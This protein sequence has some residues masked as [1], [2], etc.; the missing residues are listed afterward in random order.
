VTKDT[1]APVFLLGVNIGPAQ[2]TVTFSEDVK[3]DGSAGAAD[4]VANYLLFEDGANNV[5]NTV[6]CLGGVVADD[7]NIVINSVTYNVATFTVT[8]NINGSVPL[9]AGTYRLLVCG[10][11]SIED[12]A[13][14]KLN[15]GLADSAF[16]FTVVPA[17]AAALP[18][19]GFAPGRVTVL[20][21]QTVSYA[22]MGDLWLEIPKLGVQ[23]NIVGVPKTDGTW[24]VSWLGKYA[25]WLDGSA[26]PTWAGNSVLTGH[27]WN[28]DNSAG[29]FLAIN[30]L[31]WGDKVIIHA[32]G[33]QYVY[34]VRSVLQVSPDNT[35]TMMKHEELP[36]I[37]LVT[38]RGYDE[39]SN[40]Y[41]YRVLV[42]A[43]L[44]NEK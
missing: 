30:T 1:T 41:K 31:W 28:A 25:G 29:P 36:W 4:N 9:P 20:P 23:M 13:G 7:T 18:A 21:E 16:N 32:W 22:G 26:F 38:C 40:S 2:L 6:N 19:T 8:L 24:D 34:E 33:G 27:V 37:T 44:V 5:I 39:T 43:V 42:R 15:G 11:T 14:N 12:L 17:T 10:T 3:H 35:S